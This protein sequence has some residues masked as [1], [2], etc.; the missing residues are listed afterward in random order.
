MS[1]HVGLCACSEAKR[2]NPDLRADIAA[3]EDKKRYGRF[4]AARKPGSSPSPSSG[5]GRT[6]N[7]YPRALPDFNALLHRSGCAIACLYAF[8][9]LR[10]GE[11]DL[12]GVALVERRALLRE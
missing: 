1:G 2:F 5:T 4:T 7:G 3:R 12:R 10:V 8:D 6:C 11:K 9:L